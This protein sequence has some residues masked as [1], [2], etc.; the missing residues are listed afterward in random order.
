[1]RKLNIFI[2]ATLSLCILSGCSNNTQDP[3]STTSSNEEKTVKKKIERFTR[4][5]YKT[6]VDVVNA[7]SIINY[8]T[9]TLPSQLNGYNLKL[10]GMIDKNT[11]LTYAYT[12][13]YYLPK[14]Q[15]LVIYDRKKVKCKK[16][17]D[18]CST[19]NNFQLY[20]LNNKYLVMNSRKELW[21]E[22]EGCINIYSFDNETLTNIY[23]YKTHRENPN[24]ANSE[25]KNIVLIENELWFGDDYKLSRNNYSPTIY[26]Y[27][28][29]LGN[30]RE[31]ATGFKQPFS[32]GIEIY[33]II[34]DKQKTTIKDVVDSDTFE[35][36]NFVG[37]ICSDNKSTYYINEKVIDDST[38]A[39]KYSVINLDTNKP[40]LST[41]NRIYNLKANS[42]F[43]CWS[44]TKDSKPVI[45]DIK[46][47]KLAVFKDLEN[48]KTSFIL[49]KNYGVLKN[50]YLDEN[51]QPATK[52]Y[53]FSTKDKLGDITEEVSNPIFTD[54]EYSYEPNS[55]QKNAIYYS[56]INPSQNEEV[57]KRLKKY[58]KRVI[59]PQ[60]PSTANKSV[61]DI[62][63][64]HA[65]FTSAI[66]GM[67]KS[68]LP[69]DISY[70]KTSANTFDLI[71]KHTRPIKDMKSITFYL[72]NSETK[73]EKEV[74]LDNMTW[75]TIVKDLELNN[76]YAFK[77]SY[78]LSDDSFCEYLGELNYTGEENPTETDIE[79]YYLQ[80][81][82]K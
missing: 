41:E 9:L 16:L 15:S 37:S 28:L 23:A 34:N 53:L 68:Q 36:R 2:I 14:K 70:K 7:K 59:E 11:F 1:M 35:A 77:V 25:K 19:N 45:Y 44:T 56:G 47:G 80:S 3:E 40:I 32:N 58:F 64:A 54:N 30:I 82:I 22:N 20:G 71:F 8:T 43:L 57:K 69:F 17:F 81:N 52:Y 66:F 48:G 76:S 62:I 13:K 74:N 27:D 21:S 65:P 63:K 51:N 55:L 12:G 46:T 61:N 60:L 39:K 72:S 10:K 49:N 38:N 75:A 73:Y 6:S 18:F 78:K 26:K 50:D 67:E 42:N 4:D 24:A 31:V 29:N 79:M 33:G 5:T